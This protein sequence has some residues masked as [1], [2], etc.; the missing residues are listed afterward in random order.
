MSQTPGSVELDRKVAEA[1]GLHGEIRNLLGESFFYRTP[2]P[3][4][5]GTIK[6]RPSTDLNDAFYA[7]EQV[8]LFNGH[9]LGRGGGPWQIVNWD[10]PAG[11]EH[12][13]LASADTPA[14]A[15]CRGILSL[16]EQA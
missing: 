10:E 16:K 6:F 4:S 14:L 3:D 8:G 5:P 12:I 13:G 7:A 1:I 2:Y 11:Y 15:I 9:N